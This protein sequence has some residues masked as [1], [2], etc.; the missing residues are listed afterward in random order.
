MPS[1]Q[2]SGLERQ[3]SIYPSNSMLVR[4]F[5]NTRHYYQEAV[6]MRHS[7][8]RPC[9]LFPVRLVRLV[10]LTIHKLQQ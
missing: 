6:H 3:I 4:S 1:T 5:P 9:I 7:I 2:H 8:S 10:P